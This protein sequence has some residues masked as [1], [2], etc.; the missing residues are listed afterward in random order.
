MLLGTQSGTNSLCRLGLSILRMNRW[1]D[2][3][4]DLEVLIAGEAMR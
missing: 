1:R 4:S 2:I 3:L